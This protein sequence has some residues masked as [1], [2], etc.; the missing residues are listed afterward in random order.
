MAVVLIVVLSTAVVVGVL[1]TG[2]KRVGQATRPLP[3]SSTALDEVKRDLEVA[4]LRQETSAEGRWRPFVPLAAALVAAI[5][6][7]FAV[8]KYVQER[9]VGRE[10]RVDENIDRALDQ[11]LDYPAEGKSFSVRASTALHN[12]SRWVAQ[13]NDIAGHTGRVTSAIIHAVK[14]DVDFLDP[15]QAGFDLIC[16][17][18]WP[19]YA[20]HLASNAHD[21][22]EVLYRYGRALRAL[23]GK[24]EDY[25][26]NIRY[27]PDGFRPARSAIDIKTF[28]LLS[29][30]AEGYRVQINLITDVARR[31][32]AIAAFAEA[33][34]NQPLTAD[35]F[36]T[37]AGMPSGKI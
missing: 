1:A 35:I 4:K 28:P 16:I 25:V 36:D 29:R 17:R 34:R 14:D 24:D 9:R 12:L 37:G 22:D 32:R 7:I 30:L 26:T 27:G 3:T 19:G 20:R 5:A 13:S 6:G 11:L 18:S 8:V 31:D 2:G 10:I 21:Q 33:T 23:R 15:H